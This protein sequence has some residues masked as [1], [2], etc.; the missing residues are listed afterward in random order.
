MASVTPTGEGELDPFLDFTVA[1]FRFDQKNDFCTF[2][3]GT[4]ILWKPSDKIISDTV[5]TERENHFGC[6]RE[7]ENTSFLS[8][9][10]EKWIPCSRNVIT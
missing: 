9:S 5:E 4:E 1:K 6:E 7:R 8:F 2:E 3:F 10:S